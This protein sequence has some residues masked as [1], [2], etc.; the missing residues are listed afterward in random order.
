MNGR[1]RSGRRSV[2]AALTIVN[3][4]GLHARAAS[5]FVAVASRFA[6]AIEVE[7]GGRKVD[8]RSIL[9]VLSLVGTRGS[10]IV[11][12]A[13]GDDAAEA[14]AALGALAAAGFKDDEPA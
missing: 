12:T 4:R 7:K 2:S 13:D 8:G 14:L 6:S 10:Q 3:E 9:G 1:G 11:V 5:S